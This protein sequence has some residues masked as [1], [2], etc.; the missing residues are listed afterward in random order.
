MNL[1]STLSLDNLYALINR[2]T[3][4]TLFNSIDNGNF[5]A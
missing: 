5:Y 3:G 4:G 1:D 2:H